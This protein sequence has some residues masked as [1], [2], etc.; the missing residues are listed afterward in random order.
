MQVENA[1]HGGICSF[2]YQS[3]P[4]V[5]V[6]QPKVPIA[7]LED[8]QRDNPEARRRLKEIRSR[9]KTVP[10]EFRYVRPGDPR[11]DEFA[12]HVK[13]NPDDPEYAAHRGRMKQASLAMVKPTR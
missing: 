13:A 10:P 2:C 9:A 4:F 1:H 3:S 11:W 12:K 5:P 8:C 6:D 7:H